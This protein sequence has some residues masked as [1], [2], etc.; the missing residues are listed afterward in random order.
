MFDIIFE[1]S[2]QECFKLEKELRPTKGIGWNNA[3]GGS[4]GWRNGFSHS[5]ETKEKLK[6]AWTCERRAA[7]SHS[8]PEHSEKMKGRKRPDHTIK[9]SGSNNPMFGKTQPEHV[10]TAISAARKGKSPS[11]KIEFYCKVSPTT[12]LKYH[13]LGKKNCVK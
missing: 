2:R 3:V 10:R 9:M 8:R 13:G 1:G 12:L 7:A 6:N 5:D 11:N 4:H